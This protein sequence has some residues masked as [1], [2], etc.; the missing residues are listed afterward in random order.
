MPPGTCDTGD[1]WGPA[2]H[3]ILWVDH[4]AAS[5]DSFGK[6]TR[7]TA[8]HIHCSYIHVTAGAI[9]VMMQR[10]KTSEVDEQGRCSLEG[11]AAGLIP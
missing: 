2:T 3:V 5:E 11:L 6:A 1:A 8:E 4:R 10:R 9:Q 7:I